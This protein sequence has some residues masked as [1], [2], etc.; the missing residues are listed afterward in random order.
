MKGEI[1]QGSAPDRLLERQSKIT[2]ANDVIDLG[3]ATRLA[4][5]RA[6]AER[7]PEI[8]KAANASFAAIAGKLG[9]TRVNHRPACRKCS[10]P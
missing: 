8:L 4:V 9:D 3:N 6:Q 1:I 7:D 5:W 2:L 10:Q